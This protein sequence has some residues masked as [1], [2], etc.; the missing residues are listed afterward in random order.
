MLGQRL[1]GRFGVLNGRRPYFVDECVVRLL[2]RLKFVRRRRGGDPA[3]LDE[4]NLRNPPNRPFPPLSSHRS[5]DRLLLLGRQGDGRLA[6]VEL[7]HVDA[8]VVAAL[9]RAQHDPGAVRVEQRDRGRLAPAGASR[10]RRS[11]RS[12]SARVSRPCAGRR[13]RWPPRSRPLR[14]GDRRPGPGALIAKSTRSRLLPV[15]PIRLSRLPQLAARVAARRASE[16]REDEQPR[17]PRRSRS[18]RP[19]A[20]EVHRRD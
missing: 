4:W 14:G 20:R 11:G 5:L 12:P 7:L 9:D 3:D 2:V 19:S 17:P 6:L 1:A 10:R 18:S 16:H 8:R 13:G 15:S